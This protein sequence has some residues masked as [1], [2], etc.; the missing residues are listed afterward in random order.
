MSKNAACPPSDCQYVASLIYSRRPLPK[1]L[2]VAPSV[3]DIDPRHLHIVCVVESESAFWSCD[4][5]R[6]P[7]NMF[8]YFGDYTA[9][10]PRDFDVVGRPANGTYSV[11]WLGDGRLIAKGA[12]LWPP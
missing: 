6:V 2:L 8:S 12:F 3:T 10:F 7:F 5:A 1:S 11:S 4:A 9:V